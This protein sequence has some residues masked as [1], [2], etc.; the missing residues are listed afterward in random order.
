MEPV[1]DLNG[2]VQ[3]SRTN[4]RKFKKMVRANRYSEMTVYVCKNSAN[5]FT[6]EEREYYQDISV[7]SKFSIIL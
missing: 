7:K 6:K 3:Y 5:S 4:Q 2:F 1:K